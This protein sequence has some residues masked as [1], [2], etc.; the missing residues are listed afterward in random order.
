MFRQRGWVTPQRAVAIAYV[1]CA[2][3]SSMDANIVNVMLPTITANFHSSLAVTQWTIIGYVLAL[4]IAMPSAAWLS[5]QFGDRRVLSTAIVAFGLGSAACGLAADLPMLIACRFVQG[6]AGGMLMPVATSMLYKTFPPEARAR[7]TRTVLLPIALGP[8]ASPPL[9]GLFATHV[10]WRWAFF[11]N[12]PV[13]VLSYLLVTLKMPG[14]GAERSPARFDRPGFV[15]AG[16]G[17]S[18]TLL[19]LAQGDEWGWAAPVIVASMV[20]GPACLAAFA[21]VEWRTERPLLDLRLLGGALFRQTNI[22]T[23]CQTAAFLGGLIYITPIFL[24]RGGLNSPLMAGLVTAAVPV[25]VVTTAQTVG[26]RYSAIGPRRMVVAGEAALAAILA[27]LS[28]LG[29]AVPLWAIAALL[30]GAGLANGS[31]MVGLQTSM[32]AQV[33]TEQTPSAAT[34][35]NINRQLTTALS[36]SLATIVITALPAAGGLNFRVA[37]LVTASLAA[38]AAFSGA[39]IDDQLAASTRGHPPAIAPEGEG[40]DGARTRSG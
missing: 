17:L 35:W 26:R 24:Q 14:V 32:F 4:S 12:V 3:T 9:G 34:I 30:L 10:S 21:R 27:V 18:A 6:A 31:A 16:L 7:L 29:P 15:L 25:G 5:T 19:V 28:F 39:F 1:T 22:A 33:S 2:L 13:C 37:Y 36:V 23:T 20:I 40:K 38:L 8:A 11:V